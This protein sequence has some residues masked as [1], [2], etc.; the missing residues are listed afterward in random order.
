MLEAVGFDLDGTLFDDRQY[1]RAG[2]QNAGYRLETV[3]GTDLSDELVEAYFER[4]IR[5][6]TF[7]VVLDEHDLPAS[8]VPDLV[9]AYHDNDADLEPYP[10]TVRTLETLG[11][12][13]RLGLVTG[14]HNGRDKL[15]RLGLTEYF[16]A[17]VTTAKQSCTKREP[18]PF[19]AMIDALDVAATATVYVGDRHE[20]DCR[21]PNRLGMRTIRVETGQWPVEGSTNDAHPE[22][23]VDSIREVPDAVA[24]I[25]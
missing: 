8:L 6:G 1:A 4:G 10:G 2:L 20:L 3:V 19:R 24:A 15:D 25:G 11:D 22:A 9:A 18:E 7:D 12:R 13:Y 17:V 14:G 16:G 5:E 23:I 21:I